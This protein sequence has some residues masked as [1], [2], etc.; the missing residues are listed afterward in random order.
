[1]HTD[2]VRLAHYFLS[3]SMSTV[4]CCPVAGSVEDDVRGDEDDEKYEDVL[5][6]LSFMAE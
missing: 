3:S 6:M 1:M 4:F 2:A 5:A